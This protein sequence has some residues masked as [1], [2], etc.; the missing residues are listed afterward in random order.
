M[1][2]AFSAPD[3]PAEANDLTTGQYL[4]AWHADLSVGGSIRPTTAKAYDVAIR[5]HIVPRLGRVPLRLLSRG[6][7]KGMYVNLQVRGRA[8]KPAGGLSPKATP[9]RP[10]DLAPRP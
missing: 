9:Q 4:A 7:I 10:S 1:T 6:L 2:A 8:R 3:A 5:V